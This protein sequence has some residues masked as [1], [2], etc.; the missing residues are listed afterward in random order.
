[1]LNQQKNHWFIL[2]KLPWVV[3]LAAF[4]L[5]ALTLNHWVTLRSVAVAAKVTGWDWNLPVEWPLFYTLTFPLRLL[6]SSLQ[7]IGLNAFA[8]IC[9]ALTL[10]I[11]VRSVSLLPHDRTHEQRLREQSDHSLL[12]IP[13]RWVPPLLAALVCGL[14]LTF[15]EHS[16]ALTHES[17]DLLLL[18]TVIWTLLEFRV[19]HNK[20][21]IFIFSFVYGIG[22]P[23]NLALIGFAPAFAV[24]LIWMFGK[25]IFKANLILPMVGLALAGLLFY[26]LLPTVWVIQHGESFKFWDVLRANLGAQKALLLDTPSLRSRVLI[27]CLTSVLPILVMGIRWPQ[28]FGE[29]SVTGAQLTNIIFRVVHF[30]FFAACLFVALDHKFSPRAL[31]MGIPL[32]SLYYLGALCIGYYSGYL[33]LVATH[34]NLKNW[35]RE[36]GLISWINNLLAG[37]VYT[38]A[39]AFPCYLLYHNLPVIRSDDGSSLKQFTASTIS[40]IP[41]EPSILLSEDPTP[42]LL[43]HA[44]FSGNVQNSPHALVNLRALQNPSYQIELAKHYPKLWPK[45]DALGTEIALADVTKTLT[46][47]ALAHPVYYLHPSFGLFFESM[48][49]E[50]H[51]QI[52]RMVSY[53]KDDLLPPLVAGAILEENTAFWKTNEP[54]L[55]TFTKTGGEQSG[56]SAFLARYY[57]LTLNNWGATLQ[58][59]GLLEPAKNAFSLSL[60]LN[61]RNISANANLDFNQS[62][63]TGVPRSAQK[64]TTLEDEF[65]KLTWIDI[66]GSSGTFDDPTFGSRQAQLFLEQGFNRQSS[67][68]FDRA[69]QTQPT[70]ILARLSL[71]NAYI[72]ARRPEEALKLIQQVQKL[73]PQALSATNQIDIISMEAGAHF[74]SGQA[75]KAEAILKSGMTKFPQDRLLFDSLTELYRT[76]GE[77][78]KAIDLLERDLASHPQH[79]LGML[80]KADIL[81][82]QNQFP[83]ALRELDRVQKIVPDHVQALLYRAFISL[84]LKDYKQAQTHSERILVADPDNAQALVYLGILGQETK[85]YAFGAEALSKV[86]KKSPNNF[87]ALRNRAI[88]YLEAGKLNEAKQDYNVL[89]R[90]FPDLYSVYYGL[91]EIAWKQKDTPEA[92]KQYTLYLKYVPNDNQPVLIQEK[93]TISQRLAELK[94][95][96]R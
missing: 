28:S 9:S 23:D 66:L 72:F 58:R 57:S 33:L 59:A 46:S 21:W 87:V 56:A 70:N 13:T 81:I 75:A 52:Y 62:L 63:R 32:L 91:G 3:G 67:Y 86:L 95:A 18:A 50:P 78:Q 89:L 45:Q 12:S 2:N 22:V 19:S 40:K 51:G 77:W 90:H 8:A 6:P 27:L 25:N 35:Q 54:F 83:Q 74:N 16:I 84:Q 80:Q 10:G 14:E 4:V 31:G 71:A 64:S 36:S 94:S 88:L 39:I 38:T 68:L 30:L 48:R 92:I 1:M 73:P 7:L 15:W 47:L 34:G 65:N 29:T 17:F 49:P 82:N 5:Y 55:N 53:K 26:F 96:S 37:L 85:N 11:L 69:V 79:I 20:K 93:A 61:P 76:T 43:L 24:A 42:L 44:W 60:E 41:N